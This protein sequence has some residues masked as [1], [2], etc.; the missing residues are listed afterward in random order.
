MI[1]CLY[2]KGIP[3]GDMSEALAA[4]LGPSAGGAF[5]EQRGA[6]QGSL[7]PRARGLVEAFIGREALFVDQFPHR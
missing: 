2:L 6:A 5:G 1:P 7:G 4:L 3:T